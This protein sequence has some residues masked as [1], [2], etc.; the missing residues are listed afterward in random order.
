MAR[1]VIIGDVHGC[2]AELD[3]LLDRIAPVTGDQLIL[4]GDLVARGPKSA[5][6][7]DRVIELGAR[8]VL[9]NHERKL[10][11]ARK[12]RANGSDGP[13]LGKTHERLLEE[14]DDHHWSFIEALPLSIDL[15]E[16][17]IRVVHAGVI[18]GKPID[19]HDA[20]TLTHLRTIKT[21]GT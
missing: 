12:A 18:P 13:K 16:H 7:V 4:V 21:D 11:E 5:D 6:V 20:W 9:G 15:P 8:A 3:D 2:R 19:A 14:L 10:I 17:E 1:T